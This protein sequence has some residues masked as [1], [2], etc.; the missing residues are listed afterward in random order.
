MSNDRGGGEMKFLVG[1]FLGGIIGALII[2]FLGTKEGKKASKA[3]EEK[4]KDIVDD[5]SG[6]IGELEKKGKELIKQGEE[7]KNEVVEQLTEEK[8]VL[9]D[10]ATEKLDNALAQIEELQAQGQQSTADLRKR[11][12]KNLP[13]KR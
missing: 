10:Q 5:L 1:L 13:K 4:G 2:F 3:I 9:T 8:E 12:F 11:L 6:Q 7:I